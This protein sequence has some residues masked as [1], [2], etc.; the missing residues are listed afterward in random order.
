MIK[1][2]MIAG[3][4]QEENFEEVFMKLNQTLKILWVSKK[5]YKDY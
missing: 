1:C 2:V 4:V 3:K 5:E